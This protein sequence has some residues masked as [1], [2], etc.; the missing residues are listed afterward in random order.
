MKWHISGAPGASMVVGM[1]SGGILLVQV[2][3]SIIPQLHCMVQSG[4]EQD[5]LAL[6]TDMLTMTWHAQ[7]KHVA[8]FWAHGW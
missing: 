3:C 2:A 6:L 5:N 4:A 7:W 8:L 1:G